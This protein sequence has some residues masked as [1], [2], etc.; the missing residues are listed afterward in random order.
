MGNKLDAFLSFNERNLLTH[1][2]KIKMEV[3]QKLAAERY[4]TFDAKR[5][6]VEALQADEEDIVALEQL[7]K[8]LEGKKGAR[9]DSRRMENRTVWYL[10]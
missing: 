8:D 10:C 7:A 1:A 4:E 6:Q 3:A 9:N 2:G 5:K